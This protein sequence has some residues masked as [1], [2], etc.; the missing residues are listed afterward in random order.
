MNQ[1]Q[2]Q[3]WILILLL[4]IQ[5]FFWIAGL[6]QQSPIIFLR[7]S[8]GVKEVR[9]FKLLQS[10][11]KKK[12]E[13][14]YFLRKTMMAYLLY[15]ARVSTEGLYGDNN[16]EMDGI[17][18]MSALHACQRKGLAE[19]AIYYLNMMKQSPKQPQQRK[20]AGWKQEGARG[21]LK[22]PENV[23]YR[24]A[25]SACARGG[26]WENGITLLDEMKEVTGKAVNFF[27][28]DSYPLELI[29][30]SNNSNHRSVAGSHN[31]NNTDDIDDFHRTCVD[32]HRIFVE[33]TDTNNGSR[34]HFDRQSS[35]RSHGSSIVTN[36]SKCI[37]IVLAT[38]K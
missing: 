15:A 28:D 13:I 31:N 6:Q 36:K 3:H 26:D 19:D 24:L 10:N 21:A 12:E 5:Y 4:I 8:T 11:V 30:A 17:A 33:L 38:T 20:T 27:D 1:Q 25:I 2:G 7:Q 18:V 32:L 37:P 29:H 35:E 34:H 22:G 16:I 9:L 14:P 23:A